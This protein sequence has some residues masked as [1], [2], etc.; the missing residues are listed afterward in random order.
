MKRVTGIG[1]G[2]EKAGL[3]SSVRLSIHGATRSISQVHDHGVYG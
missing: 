3:P 1:R 2:R